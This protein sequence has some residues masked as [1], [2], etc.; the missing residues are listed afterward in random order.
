MS[1]PNY[2][3]TVVVPLLQKKVQDMNNQILFLEANMLVQ[4]ARCKWLEERLAEAVAKA[5]SASKRGKKKD[6]AVLDGQTY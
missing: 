4:Q 2:N 1:E 3:E 5:E 6:E